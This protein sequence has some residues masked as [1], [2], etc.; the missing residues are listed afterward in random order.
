ML[1]LNYTSSGL[2]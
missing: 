2:G 1:P